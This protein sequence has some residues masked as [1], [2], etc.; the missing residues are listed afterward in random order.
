[1]KG[2][3]SALVICPSLALIEQQV[4]YLNGINLRAVALT[5]RVVAPERYVLLD[6]LRE[7]G[8]DI[9]FVYVTP[10]MI[11]YGGQV[12]V[13]VRDLCARGDFSFV[14]IDDGLR[15]EGFR[16]NLGYLRE[17]RE[18][19]RDLKWIIMTTASNAEIT[20]MRC[21]IRAS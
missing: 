7:G 4:N 13:L 11:N 1:M 12:A 9:K 15:F 19:N 6:Q 5:S 2:K 10:E 20:H 8:S 21:H 16:E 14:V 3:F 18:T 17:L